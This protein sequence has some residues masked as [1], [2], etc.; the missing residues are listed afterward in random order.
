[1]KYVGLFIK[2]L[3]RYLLKPL[4]FLPAV[5]VMYLIFSFSAQD[6]TQSAVMSRELS[7]KIVVVA[8]RVLDKEWDEAQ[9]R[10]QTER[11]HY[12]VRKLAHVT[13]YFVLAVT[14]AFPLYVYKVRGIW[15]VLL[16]GAFCVAFAGLDEYHQSFVAGRGPS[17]RDVAIDSIG[18]LPG[19][20]LVR[21]VGFIG[22][23]T[24]FRPLVL[25][26]GGNKRCK[27]RTSGSKR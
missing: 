17:V 12:Y 6:G 9:I 16:A 7:H 13:E 3:L 14:V 25:H 20:I 23:K 5:A 1:M 10:F 18:I 27:K 11:I 24:I 2:K 19:I 22:R 4:S 21:I 15:L 8:D 26:E